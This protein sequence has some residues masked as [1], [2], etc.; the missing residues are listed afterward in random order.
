MAPPYLSMESIKNKAFRHQWK[1]IQNPEA[2]YKLSAD[3]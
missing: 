2:A 1:R 3:R